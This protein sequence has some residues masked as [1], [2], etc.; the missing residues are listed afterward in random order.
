MGDGVSRYLPGKQ[1]NEIK[2]GMFSSLTVASVTG[3]GLAGLIILSEGMIE[4]YTGLIPG[5]GFFIKGLAL[6]CIAEPINSLSIEYFRSF[7]RMKALS[8]LSVFDTI[9]EFVPV[10]WFAYNGFGIG[11]VIFS[12][13]C[14]RFTMGV[15]KT[16]L[17]LAENGIGDLKISM[18]TNYIRFGFPLIWANIFFYISNYI[19][20]YLLGFFH[21]AKEVGIYSLAYSIGYIVV[22]MSTPWD[23]VLNPTI[24]AQWNKGDMLGVSNYFNNSLRYVLILAIPAIVF[25]SA[26][27][28]VLVGILSTQEFLSAIYIIPAMLVTFTIFEVAIFYQRIVMLARPSDIIMKVFGASAIISLVLNI[29]LIPRFSIFGAALSLL[30]TYSCLFAIFYRLASKGKSDIAFD[31][32]L[33]FKCLLAAVPGCCIFL[34]NRNMLFFS[35]GAAMISYFTILWILHAIGKKELGFIKRLLYAHNKES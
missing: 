16:L 17:I 15:V 20:R 5:S 30:A 23:R 32:L 24:T 28:K 26:I 7:R 34:F 33:L 11:I 6:L 22:L 21:S 27:G 9:F 8:V 3:L 10:F 18:I 19:D 2:D 4:K 31:W 25:L 35:F 29:I 12:F 13:A 1:K 14:G